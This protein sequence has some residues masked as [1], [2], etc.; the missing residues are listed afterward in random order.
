MSQ[1]EV[2][3]D[4]RTISA[5]VTALEARGFTVEVVDDL[6]AVLPAVLARLPHGSRVWRSTSVTLD[7]SGLSAAGD[8]AD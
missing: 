4:E 8:S 1:F 5:I 6:E 2:L 7:E 3:P